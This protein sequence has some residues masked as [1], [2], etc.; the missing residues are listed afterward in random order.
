MLMTVDRVRNPLH[1]NRRSK[2]SETHP[3]WVRIVSSRGRCRVNGR[4]RRS[5]MLKF[6]QPDDHLAD[7]AGNVAALIRETPNV[8]LMLAD[9]V[10]FRMNSKFGL[11]FRRTIQRHAAS[12]PM[13][14]CHDF[15]KL[16]DVVEVK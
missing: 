3:P 12:H 1:G 13:S 9:E 4:A 5:G 7:G 16:D 15:Q 11:R 8:R 10:G 14:V 2:Q 6:S